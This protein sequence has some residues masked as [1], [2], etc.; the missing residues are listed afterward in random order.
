MNK[1]N[2]EEFEKSIGYKFNDIKLLETALKHSSYAFDTDSESYER[3]EYL[4]DSILEFVSSEY[5][6]K[7]YKDLSEG[8]M[9]KVRSS[10]VCEDNL[11]K[12]AINH[13]IE[14]Y[15]LLGKSETN[16]VGNHKAIFADMIE[17]I[18]A[19]IYLDSNLENSKKFILDNIIPAIDFASKHV[20]EK[21]YKTVLQEMLQVNGNVSIVYTIIDEAG[22]DH[23]K[24]FTA[25]VECNGKVLATGTG[26]SKKRAEMQAAKKAIENL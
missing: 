6:F 21:D 1:I 4:G 24:V 18:I 20:G 26:G 16:S 7:N 13:N 17:A 2:Y 8:E 25:Q 9:T 5:L 10:A 11:Y 14:K 23:E 19:A 22:P 15:A 3:L 12:I